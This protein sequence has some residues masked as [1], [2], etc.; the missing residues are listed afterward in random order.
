MDQSV[1]VED[2]PAAARTGFV[3]WLG[4]KVAQ[5]QGQDP[6]FDGEAGH[7]QLDGQQADGNQGEGQKGC[8]RMPDQRF[9][10]L[11]G[12][13]GAAAEPG[14]HAGKDDRR[15][16]PAGQRGEHSGERPGVAILSNQ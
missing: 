1:V 2:Q 15:R 14:V 3:K 9:G 6:L 16:R 12:R 5:E 4:K 10:G 13:D 8:E 7:E 11:A